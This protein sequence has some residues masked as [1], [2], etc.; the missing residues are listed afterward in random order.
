[1]GEFAVKRQMSWGWDRATA[2]LQ[3]WFK[4]EGH[5]DTYPVFPSISI[6]PKKYLLQNNMAEVVGGS[7]EE[8][9]GGTKR[10]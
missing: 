5:F 2:G 3:S 7:K 10:G 4:M 8:R 6:H 1:M 9:T